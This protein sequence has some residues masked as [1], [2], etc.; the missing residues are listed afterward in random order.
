[1]G[2]EIKQTQIDELEAQNK[3]RNLATVTAV[4]FG[5]VAGYYVYSNTNAKKSQFYKYMLGGGLVLGLGYRLFTMEKAT[6]RKEAIKKTKATLEQ[7]DYKPAPAPID[8][9]AAPT[10]IV[11]LGAPTTGTGKPDRPQPLNPNLTKPVMILK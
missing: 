2:Q 9:S 11:D 6:R 7:G 5:V 10:T 3:R 4:I 8:S 1:M